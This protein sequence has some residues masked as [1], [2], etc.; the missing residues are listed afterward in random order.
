MR[1][2][3]GSVVRSSRKVIS[4]GYRGFGGLVLVYG[5]KFVGVAFS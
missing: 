1:V 3:L 2:Y 5:V 4:R